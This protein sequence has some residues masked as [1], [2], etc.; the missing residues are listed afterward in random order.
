MPLTPEDVVEKRFNPTRVREGYAQ[1][2]VDDFLDEVVAELRRLNG[3]NAELRGQ[4]SQCQARVAELTRAGAQPVE[5]EA[6]EVQE[7]PDVQVVAEPEPA[8]EP[9]RPVAAEAGPAPAA[10]DDA[11]ARAAGVIALAQRLHDE[12]VREGE[13]QR[14]AL[15]LAAQEEAERVVA[16][17][18]VRRDRALGE[19][20]SRRG[21]L[22]DVIQQL[23][24]RETTYREQLEQ[25]I[26]TQLE[27]LRRVARVVPDD[28]VSR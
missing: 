5:A 9:P 13:A 12:Y 6:P 28:A 20:E 2:E 17:A 26:A 23:H 11:A 27:D 8:P 10:T 4:L 7:A 1:D 18:E 22:E 16:D 25:F 3:E 15:V 14:D 21:A 19:L 24:S